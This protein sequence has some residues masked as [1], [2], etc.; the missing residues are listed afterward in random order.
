MLIKENFYTLAFTSARNEVI[1][2]IRF[3]SVGIFLNFII[4]F[5]IC[6]NW[7]DILH[8]QLFSTCKGRKVVKVRDTFML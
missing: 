4:A 3:F 7:V 8:D 1:E 5:L 6:C 2:I